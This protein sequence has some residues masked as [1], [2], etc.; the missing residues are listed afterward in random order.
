MVRGVGTSQQ[1]GRGARRLFD[2][3]VVHNRNLNIKEILK[4]LLKKEFIF[5][6]LQ[7]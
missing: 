2:E 5:Y 3:L 7:S 4:E 6:I 1:D